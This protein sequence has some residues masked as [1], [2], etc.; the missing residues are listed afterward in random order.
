MGCL[1]G[2]EARKELERLADA[3]V[4]NEAFPWLTHQEIPIGYCPKERMLRVNFIG[5][6]GWELHHPIEY[7][8]HLFDALMTVAVEFGSRLVGLRAMDS[9]RLE[10][11]YRMWGTLILMPRIPCCKPILDVF[12]ALIKANSPG[13]IL[14]CASRKTA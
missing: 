10:K 14:W 2:P 5:S 1:A 12:C 3:D 7:Q 11:S 9:M 6:L 8:N 13:V 4:S